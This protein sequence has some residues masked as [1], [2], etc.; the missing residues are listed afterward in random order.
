MVILPDMGVVFEF[1][2]LDTQFGYKAELLSYLRV[3]VVFTLFL[4]AAPL[5]H[6]SVI[7]LVWV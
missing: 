4:S 7:V 3:I 1:K 2:H 5:G 6:L